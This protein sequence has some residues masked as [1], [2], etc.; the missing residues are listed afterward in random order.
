VNTKF[1]KINSTKYS[2][3]L[4]IGSIKIGC[5]GHFVVCFLLIIVVILSPFSNT[6]ITTLLLLILVWWALD[7]PG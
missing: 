4:T 3:G 6:T 2:D 1:E 7:N 5:D